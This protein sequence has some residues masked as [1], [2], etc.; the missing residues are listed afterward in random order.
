MHTAMS[1]NNNPSSQYPPGPGRRASRRGLLKSAAVVLLPILAIAAVG[2]SFVFVDETESVIVERLGVITAVYDRPEDRGPH[3][4]CPWPIDIVRRF[5]NRVQ[6]FDPPGREI[7]T[8]DKKNITVATYVCWKIADAETA[9]AADI[10][11]RPVVRFFFSGFENVGA[12]EANLD[13]RLRNILTTSIGQVEL[14]ELLDV[15]DSELGPDNGGVGRMDKLSAQMRQMLDRQPGEQQSLKEKLGIEIVDVRIKRLNLPLGNQQAVFERMRSERRKIADR[16]RSAGMAENAMIKSQADRQ[17]AEI[18]AK[19]ARRAEEIRGQS[20]A[21]SIGILNRAHSQD[22]ELH[23]VLQTLDTYR[24][25]LNEKTT[26]VLS[27]SSNLLKLLTDGIP[28][29]PGEKESSPSV[30]SEPKKDQA[31]NK[32][33]K[34]VE[35][36]SASSAKPDRSGDSQPRRSP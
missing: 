6:L 20:E 5:D 22:P 35:P 23:R 24:S 30:P 2:S 15:T 31:A 8:R 29:L 21:E 11:T 25:I 17:Y 32:V 1:M 28:D 10:N 34:L 14:N 7:F 12:A 9:A 13:V 27:A 26:L 18:L 16:Y 3:V 4:K 36:K 19:A 33:S